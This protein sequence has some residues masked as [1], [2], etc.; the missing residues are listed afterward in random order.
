MKATSFLLLALGAA[1]ASACHDYQYC[2]CYDS[3]GIQNDQATK[4]VC[5]QYRE[6]YLVD[7]PTAGHKQCTSDN[8]VQIRLNNCDWRLACQ[9]NEAT[10]QQGETGL[11]LALAASEG[12]RFLRKDSGPPTP[13]THT[14]TTPTTSPWL[15]CSLKAHPENIES[16]QYASFAMTPPALFSILTSCGVSSLQ[17]CK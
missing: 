4:A 3:D 5:D 1:S 10:G 2:H 14:A 13:T 7:G 8:N 12:C 17:V 6:T 9:N 16:M 15:G 11:S